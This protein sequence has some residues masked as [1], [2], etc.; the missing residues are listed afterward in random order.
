MALYGGDVDLNVQSKHIPR[1]GIPPSFDN[2]VGRAEN[3]VVNEEDMLFGDFMTRVVENQSNIV[4]PSYEHPNFQLSLDV[5]NFFS[6]TISVYGGSMKTHT[7]IF[8]D[9]W[10]LLAILNKKA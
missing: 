4:Y 3:L 5:I 2:W 1:G 8:C 7:L 10:W 6:Y 9:L